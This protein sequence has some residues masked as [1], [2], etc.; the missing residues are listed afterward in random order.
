METP[1]QL[2][3]PVKKELLDPKEIAN[4]VVTT[5]KSKAVYKTIKVF[6]ESEWHQ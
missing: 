6:P 4:L 2:T 1:M 3:N 5:I